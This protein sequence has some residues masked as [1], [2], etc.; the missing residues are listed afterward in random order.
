MGEL[1]ELNQGE[2]KIKFSGPTSGKLTF[3]DLGL[4]D[5]DLVLEGGLLRMVFD[6]EG[7]GVVV[8]GHERMKS[9]RCRWRSS[10]SSTSSARWRPGGWVLGIPRPGCWQGSTACARWSSRALC[11]S[12]RARA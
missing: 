5:E 8:E 4:K 11:C 7:V 10:V 12:R 3:A 1:V 2:I 9:R 6:L